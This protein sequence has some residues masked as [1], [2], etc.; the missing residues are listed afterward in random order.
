MERSVS[1]PCVVSA[2]AL[3]RTQYAPVLLRVGP[4]TQRLVFA[5]KSDLRLNEQPPTLE[6]LTATLSAKI[7]REDREQIVVSL[8][9]RGVPTE[10]SIAKSVFRTAAA[11]V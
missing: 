10:L 1:I 4:N 5:Q 3:W 6:E 9:T 8:L 2:K 11:S 7:L